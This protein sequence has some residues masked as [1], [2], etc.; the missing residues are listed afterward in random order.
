M[1]NRNSFFVL[2]LVFTLQFT[3]HPLPLVADTIARA[4]TA[5][6]NKSVAPQQ[7][8]GALDRGYR[9]GYSDGYQAGWRDSLDRAARDA[10]N[11]QEYLQADRAYVATYGSLEDYRDGYR[12]GFEMG[13]GVGYDRR[14]F[15]STVPAELTRRDGS[16]RGDDNHRAGTASGDGAADSSADA[17]VMTGGSILIPAD[18]NMRVELLHSL[19]TDASMRGDRFEARV[20]EPRQYE[21]ATIEG[22]VSNVRRPGKLR[23]TAELQLTFDQIRFT[24]NRALPFNAQVIEAI[25][26]DE[27]TAGDVDREGGVRG[28][29][30]TRDD[31][32]KIGSGAAIGA[33]IGA[34]AGGGKG[35]AIGAVIGGGVAT[36]GAIATR[37]KDVRLERGQQM[38]LRTAGD[39]RGQ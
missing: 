12:Q 3:A 6:F 16:G 36:G 11:K 38:M 30:S 15:D 10:R 35:A 27:G 34:I 7:E 25:R 13:Y 21:G 19:S 29:D 5:P 32:T 2:L 20:L 31:A 28:R 33:V 17:A 24:D 18:T 1:K 14:S 39:T 23:G 22:R 4:S 37:G 26:H 8:A 9:T